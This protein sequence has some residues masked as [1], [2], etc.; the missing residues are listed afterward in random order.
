MTITYKDTKEFTK[1]QL[2]QLFQSVEWDSGKYPDLLVKAMLGT[3]TVFSA[4]DGE[5]LIGLVSTMDD[6]IM[7]AYT[8]YL[9]VNPNYQG[10][11]IG[12]SLMNKVKEYYKE[13]KTLV[14]IAS[15]GKSVFYE[16]VGYTAHPETT[17]MFLKF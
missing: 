17:S 15:E 16:G 1:E 5:K 11:S 13:Y 12:K 2:E 9:L 3:S 14:L 8:H 6:G 10:K 7:N 4:W